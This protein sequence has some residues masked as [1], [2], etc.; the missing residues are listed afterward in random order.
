MP[1]IWRNM[2]LLKESSTPEVASLI[3]SLKESS[4]NV[5]VTSSISSFLYRVSAQ[6]SI[7]SASGTLV[8]QV[9][10]IERTHV[11]ITRDAGLPDLVNKPKAVFT[12]PG[13]CSIQ[14]QASRSHATI[15]THHTVLT[16]PLTRSGVAVRWA[17]EFSASH[18]YV[19]FE[20]RLE[21][22]VQTRH[23]LSL[24]SL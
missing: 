7:T 17:C 18:T 6:I 5:V 14:A 12:T 13:H 8:K 11:T 21:R 2:V 22:S 3:G 9:N 16:H 1:S 20:S 10:Y 4:L 23:H 24:S 19:A 15:S